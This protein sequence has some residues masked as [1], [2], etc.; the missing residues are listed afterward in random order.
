MPSAT[1]AAASCLASAVPP[2][3]TMVMIASHGAARQ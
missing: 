1:R 3:I 2:K